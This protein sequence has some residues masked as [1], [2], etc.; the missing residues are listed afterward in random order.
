MERL[1][2]ENKYVK[3]SVLQSPSKLPPIGNQDLIR[4]LR[5]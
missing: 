1:R 2:I 4:A 3:P 5:A